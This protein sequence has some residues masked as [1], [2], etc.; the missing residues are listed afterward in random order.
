MNAPNGLNCKE[1]V[2]LITAYLEHALLPT[3]QA[4]LEAHLAECPGCTAYLHQIQQT[5]VML[6]AL[7]QEAVF[8]ETKADLLHLFEQWKK[9]QHAS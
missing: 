3:T 8:P 6:R 5:I 1:V 2:E 7:S 4:Q 9:S